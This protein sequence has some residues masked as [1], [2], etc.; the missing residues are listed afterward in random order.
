MLFVAR[1]CRGFFYVGMSQSPRLRE[2]L[3]CIFINKSEY[4]IVRI[5]C[6]N[7]TNLEEKQ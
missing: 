6:E 1:L 4:R 3:N 2:N 7:A 5:I